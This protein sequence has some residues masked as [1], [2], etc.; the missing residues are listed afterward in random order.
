MAVDNTR[1]PTSRVEAVARLVKRAHAFNKVD[2]DCDDDAF[3]PKKAEGS[4]GRDIIYC[5][6]CGAIVWRQ[7]QTADVG[8]QFEP[9]S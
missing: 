7:G 1:L 2:R 8:H 9:A 5:A 3:E 4:D 6:N